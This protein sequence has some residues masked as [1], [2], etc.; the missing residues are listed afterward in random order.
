MNTFIEKENNTFWGQ[1][2]D[3]EQYYPS[4]KNTIISKN[5]EPIKEDKEEEEEEEEEKKGEDEYQCCNYNK[6][7][8]YQFCVIIFTIFTIF[9]V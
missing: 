8:Y 1:Y 2:A 7:L 4:I 6:I 3:I 5:L 9:M